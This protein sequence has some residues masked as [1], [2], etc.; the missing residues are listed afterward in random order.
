[1]S[2]AT[3][4]SPRVLS[5]FPTSRVGNGEVHC[6]DDTRRI[7]YGQ[8]AGRVAGVREPTDNPPRS[9]VGQDRAVTGQ[10]VENNCAKFARVIARTGWSESRSASCTSISSIA[11]MTAWVVARAGLQPCPFSNPSV[12]WVRARDGRVRPTR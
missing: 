4:D 7:V 5:T 8:V 1:M 10:H 12:R 6:R 2:A 11:S 3:A 9:V